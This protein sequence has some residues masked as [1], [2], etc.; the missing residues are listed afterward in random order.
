MR[1]PKGVAKPKWE[2]PTGEW[3]T[4]KHGASIPRTGGKSNWGS[5]TE[6]VLEQVPEQV[7]HAPPP[8]PVPIHQTSSGASRLHPSS[9]DSLQITRHASLCNHG[10][11]GVH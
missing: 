6:Q 2:H 7:R 4:G 10:A 3:E 11:T 9:P 5:F 8:S 1:G